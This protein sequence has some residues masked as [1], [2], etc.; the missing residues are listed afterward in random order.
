M[1]CEVRVPLR[2]RELRLDVGYRLDMLVERMVIVENKAVERI[3]QVHK[4]QILTYLELTGLRLGYLLNWN[5]PL[6]K[7]GIKRFVHRF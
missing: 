4:A 1:E 3:L 2:Y 6:M 5:S 7:R